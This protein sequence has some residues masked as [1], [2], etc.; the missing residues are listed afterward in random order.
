MDVCGWTCLCLRTA[1]CFM[2]SFHVRGFEA[3][4]IN[5]KPPLGSLVEDRWQ[6]PRHLFCGK[7]YMLYLGEWLVICLEVDFQLEWASPR[8][9]CRRHLPPRRK[10]LIAY[11]SPD[12]CQLARPKRKPPMQAHTN[13]DKIRLIIRRYNSMPDKKLDQNRR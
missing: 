9:Q 13:L 7:C 6:H 11:T 5:V 4:H 10:P 3:H 8:E 12:L 1:P 2:I